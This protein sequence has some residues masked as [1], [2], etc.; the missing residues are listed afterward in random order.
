VSGRPATGFSEPS[1]PV[2]PTV[3]RACPACPARRA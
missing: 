2:P 1:L 3:F